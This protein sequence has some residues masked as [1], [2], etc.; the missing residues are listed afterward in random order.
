[1]D[2]RRASDV[3][4]SIV[5]F[6]PSLS[7]IGV[8]L[9]LGLGIEYASRRAGATRPR[10]IS[11]VSQA[12]ASRSDATDAVVLLGCRIDE[13][14]V[15]GAA[16]MRRARAA[17][18]HF[19]ASGARWMVICGGRRWGR[20]AE[21]IALARVVEGLGVP[22]ERIVTELCSMSTFE[23][24]R[25]AATWLERLEVGS[26]AVVTCDW[27]LPRA[28]DSFRHFGVNAVGVAAPSPR[29]NVVAASWRSVRERLSFNLDRAATVGW[30][31]SP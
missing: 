15:P 31:R 12:V 2:R 23:N 16:G 7:R 18:A 9:G 5:R 25:Y 13:S 3:P 11:F 20:H 14:G 27:H 29:R 6:L 24:A 22:Q 10:E 26:A 8:R 19:H 28:L 4:C 21:A 17:A 30:E 1:M